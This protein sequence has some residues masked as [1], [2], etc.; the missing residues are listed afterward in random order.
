M[1]NKTT[2][3]NTQVVTTIR[4]PSGQSGQ[5]APGDLVLIKDGATDLTPVTVQDI[6]IAGLY[7]F[8]FTPTSTG[9][10]TLFAYGAIQAVIEVTTKSLYS[11][12]ENIEDEALGSWQWD[13]TNGTLVMLRQDGTQLAN[14]T[15]IDTLTGASRERTT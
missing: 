2:V 14:F 15:V 13:K 12:L 3:I 9:T 1:I 4:N 5:P 10:Y 7:N 11:Y 6:G 8:R